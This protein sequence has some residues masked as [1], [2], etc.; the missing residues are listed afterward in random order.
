MVRVAAVQLAAESFARADA[1]LA[2]ALAGVTAAAEQGAELIVLPECSW[3]S[4]V[5]GSSWQARWPH[6]PPVDDVLGAFSTAAREA[7]AVLVA[8]LAV[9]EAGQLC[10]R[11]V[12]WERDGRV[13]GHVDKRFLW[14]FDQRWFRAGTDSPVIPTSAGVL[15]VLVCAD[16]RMPEIARLLAVAGAE[17]IV[18][19]TAWVTSH[20][21]PTT[22][23]NPQYEH[24]LPTRAIENG[25]HA[26]AA[27][28]V[29]VEADGV[30]YCGRSCILAPDGRRLAT[31]PP[32]ETAVVVADCALGP[33]RWPV[34]RRPHL[35]G[36][37]TQPTTQLPVQ[38]VLAEP[39][40]PRDSRRRL[41]VS[42]LGHPLGP[43][44]SEL[45]TDL[46]VHLVV[47]HDDVADVADACSL[48][49]HGDRAELRGDG[50]VR[51][52]WRRTHGVDAPGQEIGP[53]TAT[54]AGRVG[55]LFGPDGLGP[56]PARALM[57]AGADLIVWFV[58]EEDV[59][60]LA[61]TRAAENRCHVLLTA[62]AHAAVHDPDGRVLAASSR[63]PRILTAAMDLCASRAKEMAPGT[64]VVSG[65]QPET[66][67]S[68][69]VPGRDIAVAP[70]SRL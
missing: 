3:P 2:A 26:V 35:Y 30:A 28:K 36:I 23:T 70:S 7:D 29:G 57:L 24:M 33:A 15:G 25:L 13:L 17:I 31:G 8:G 47:S 64:D 27:N 5:I 54:P 59:G 9:P 67:A 37:L 12:V 50:Q 46:G 6:L 10:N 48:V 40:V 42:T 16:G 63:L 61:A 52:T 69:C 51:A 18:D 60:P 44:E 21:D 4:Y 65:R 20:P 66:Y 58:D 45:L 68:L 56:E 38:D 22:W 49:R 32:D 41:A 43:A 39:L 34:S 53:V 11:A 14:D 1:A 19:P 55:V 62:S